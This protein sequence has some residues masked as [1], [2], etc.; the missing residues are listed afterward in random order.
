MDRFLRRIEQLRTEGA[1]EY[2]NKLP[3]SGKHQSVHVASVTTR[4]TAEVQRSTQT[5]NARKSTLIEAALILY[6]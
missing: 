1:R 6:F 2:T 5:D 4:E 3:D